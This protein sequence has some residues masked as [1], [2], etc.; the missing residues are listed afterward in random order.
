MLK[1][2]SITSEELQKAKSL[3][4]L[5]LVEGKI[6]SEALTD[7]QLEIFYALVFRPI[8]RINIISCTQ[9]G[10]SLTVALACIVITC[11]YGERVAVLA[12]TDAKTKL[13]MR[14]YVEHLGDNAF[15]YNKLE[16]NTKLERL[17]QEESKN[18]II[19]KNGGG[20]FTVSAQAGNAKKGIEAA[21]GEG[22]KIVILDEA[23]LV[24][25]AVEAT[26]FR[27][28]SGKGADACYV[29]IGNPFYSEPPYEHFYKSS[30][31]PIYLQVFIDYHQALREGRY[32]QEFIDEAK[33]KPLFGVLYECKF[34]KTSE[35]DEKG[36]RRLITLEELRE[37]FIPKE[38]MP[39]NMVGDFRLGVDIARGGN[40]NAYVGRDNKYMWVEGINKSR[41]LMTNVSE[42]R[43]IDADFT[44]LDDTAIGG[45]VTD[46]CIEESIYVL[47]VRA[48]AK[49]GDSERFKNV[50]AELFFKFGEW[51]RTGGKLEESDH[52]LLLY[53]VKWKI[54]SSGKYCLE[55]KEEMQ[56]RMKISMV[57]M[58]G[59]SS[60][61]VIDAG[62]FTFA[63]AK[64][65]TIEDID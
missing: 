63:D 64:K 36:Y 33:G 46:R 32:N 10:K 54:D 23:G 34:P 2:L 44:A 27:M 57:A 7:G 38:K 25:D 37:C 39:E 26:I 49:A 4:D 65:P 62:S 1:D 3:A 18:R 45:G 59:S 31:N 14:Y 28:I 47:P 11:L 8:N 20:I 30:H 9:Y 29:K 50:R 61:D 6:G 60:P 21:M 48:G 22:A 56:K 17:K 15:F 19:L 58:T 55:P 53:E 43:R 12:P 35:I 16:A 24:P 41:N 40:F 42:I 51:L 52:W 5:F 13:I